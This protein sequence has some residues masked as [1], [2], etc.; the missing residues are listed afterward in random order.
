M[1]SSRLSRTSDDYDDVEEED[2]DDDVEEEDDDDV[3]DTL[4]K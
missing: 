4:K 1:T 3:V 2:V